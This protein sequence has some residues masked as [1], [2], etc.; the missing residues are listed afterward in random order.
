MCHFQCSNKK[1]QEKDVNVGEG[2]K[3]LGF[4]RPVVNIEAL[5]SKLNNNS[6]KVISIPY[7]R[8]DVTLNHGTLVSVNTSQ[9]K[10]ETSKKVHWKPDKT[11]NH[12]LYRDSPVATVSSLSSSLSSDTQQLGQWTKKSAN[13]LMMGNER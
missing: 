5:R 13:F 12:N 9:N 6:N 4:S 2:T 3:K 10:E 8:K 1:F 7:Q 11:P